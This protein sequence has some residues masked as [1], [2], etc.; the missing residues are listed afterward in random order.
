MGVGLTYNS[1]NKYFWVEDVINS[2]GLFVGVTAAYSF[3]V[4]CGLAPIHM[5]K[6]LAET[7]ET[8]TDVLKKFEEVPLC[9]PW[10]YFVADKNGDMVVVEHLANKNYELVYPK[11][12]MLIKTN[13]YLH[14]NNKKFENVFEMN[15][16][17]TTCYRYKDTQNYLL[18]NK[19]SFNLNYVF[20][21]L[22]NS[23]SVFQY[24]EFLRTLWSLAID[25]YNED[26]RLIVTDRTKKE[27]SFGIK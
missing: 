11:D 6:L 19:D 23:S 18:S 1:K 16:E 5:L 17:H 26:Y 13:H 10:N 4:G 14:P 7:C 12:D 15:S 3:N 8:V 22:R 9:D 20:N 24:D 27:I 2:K 25:I 21:I